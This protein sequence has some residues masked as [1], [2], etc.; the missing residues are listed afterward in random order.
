MTVESELA[1][2][3]HELLLHAVLTHPLPWTVDRDWTHEVVA[4]DGIVIAKCPTAELAQ[5]IVAKAE[6]VAAK[7]AAHR[8][9]VEVL[10]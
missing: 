3:L 5:A 7:I 10:P 8:T 6:Q 1:Q 2:L 9:D 4:A